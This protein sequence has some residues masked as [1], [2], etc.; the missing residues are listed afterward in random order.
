MQAALA[1]VASESN[2]SALSLRRI[3]RQA[4]VVPTAFYRHFQD[5]DDLGIALVEDTFV[6]L[7]GL[8]AAVD[9]GVDVRLLV[10]GEHNDKRVSRLAARA[11]MEPLLDAGVRI[12]E[13]QR[14]MLHCKVV[15]T[16]QVAVSGS[17]NLNMRS[18]HQDDEIV[19]VLH[20]E[21]TVATLASHFEQ[22]LGDATAMQPG[23]FEER[24]LGHRIEE[25]AVSVL[26]RFL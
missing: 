10:P 2:F 24:S 20:D 5:M 8:L 26:R 17:A 18:L 22:D 4:G 9:R 19:A 14:T 11:A 7:R 1:L 15:I 3:A 23:R 13:Y 6:E 16:D 21:G 12:E 25:R